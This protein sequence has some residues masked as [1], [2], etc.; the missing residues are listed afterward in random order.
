MEVAGVNVWLKFDEM[1]LLIGDIEKCSEQKFVEVIAALK[2]W[3]FLMGLPHLRF[4]GSA[5]TW[6]V[7][8][9]AKYGNRLEAKYPAG[10]VNFS[11]EVPLEKM[12]F[13]MADNDTF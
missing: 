1:F 12:K 2:R 11:G 8:L 3:A 4:H 13:S 6:G 10:G 5:H 7:D 9:F